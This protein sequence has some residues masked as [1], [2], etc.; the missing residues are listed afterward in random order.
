MC[1]DCNKRMGNKNSII[2]LAYKMFKDSGVVYVVYKNMLGYQIET[3]EEA[4]R[5]KMNWL[6][7]TI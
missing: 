4:I 7:E 1:H 2:E 5:K 6:H 3:K